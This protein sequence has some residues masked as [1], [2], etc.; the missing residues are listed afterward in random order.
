MLSDF[1]VAILLKVVSALFTELIAR[2]H[3][4]QDVMTSNN[5]IDARLTAFK[6]AYKEAF[7]G[8][9]VTPEQREK[10]RSAISDFI[11]GSSN[12]GM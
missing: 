6:N 4:N 9:K 1:A 7:N 3:Q 10:L 12:G 2:L 8:E 11:R 5:Q